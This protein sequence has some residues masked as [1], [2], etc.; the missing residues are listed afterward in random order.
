MTYLHLVVL[1]SYYSINN[2]LYVMVQVCPSSY[3]KLKT[4]IRDVLL[5]KAEPSS[6]LQ[7][8]DVMQRLGISYHFQDEI[9]NIL[10]SIS[11]E[12]AKDQH[13]YDN[14]AFT[15]LKFR[16]LRE[17]GF[18]TTLGILPRFC[19]SNEFLSHVD[20]HICSDVVICIEWY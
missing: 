11:N 3:Y 5:E 4:N 15:A 12:S 8:I 2:G 1:F 18:P 13:T 17:N 20:A 7:T 6:K 19:Q 10:Y 14:I 9:S 16:I